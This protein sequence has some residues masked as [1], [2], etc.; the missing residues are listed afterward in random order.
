VPSLSLARKPAA[1]SWDV[2]GALQTA[3][4]TAQASLEV[5]NI[6]DHDVVLV[7]AAAGGVGLVYAQLALHSG[8]AV[9]G[10]AGPAN[11]YFLHSLGIIP[12]RY[13]PGLADRVR[14]A[15]PAP[16]TAVQDNHGREAV[17]AG[18]ELGVPPERIVAIADHAAVVEM[19]LSAP[20]RYQRSAATLQ[21][22]AEVAASGRLQIPVPTFPFEEASAAYERLE[23]GH[24]RGRVAIRL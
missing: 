8:A 19:S 21:R 3:A 6:G 18:L 7:S 24:G 10:T 5:L 16:L 13:G 15:A 17:L 14:S 9:I 22:L 23:F 4:L 1:L 20:G 2:A 12:V 11:H